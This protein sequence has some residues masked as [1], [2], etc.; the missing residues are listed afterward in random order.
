[1]KRA[2]IGLRPLRTITTGS[3]PAL[4]VGIGLPVELERLGIPVEVLITVMAGGEETK[5]L[6]L[7]GDGVEWSQSGVDEVEGRVEGDTMEGETED[8]DGKAGTPVL[9]GEILGV[10]TTV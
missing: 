6:E 3:L 8:E 4:L 10:G 1:M 7:E 9:L 2:H 5:E